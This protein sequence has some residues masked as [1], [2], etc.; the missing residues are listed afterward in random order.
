MRDLRKIPLFV[1]GFAFFEGF[2]AVFE[3]F[4]L[5]DSPV[6][7]CNEISGFHDLFQT[8][9][10]AYQTSHSSISVTVGNSADAVPLGIHDIAVFGTV[11]YLAYL[12]PL[13]V[14]D[15]AGTVSVR[16]FAYGIAFGVLNL[17]FLAAVGNPAYPVAFG[18]LNIAL[19]VFQGN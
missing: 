18:I 15:I 19:G 8:R 2:L 1:L 4:R 14:C 11:S 3:N 9:K 7:L 6:V 10:A 17:A 5:I 16:D 13:G 12:I